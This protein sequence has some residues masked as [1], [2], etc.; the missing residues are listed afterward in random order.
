MKDM[1][2]PNRLSV[3]RIL[4]IPVMTALLYPRTA[5]CGAAALAVFCIAAATDW[6]DGRI[7]R[8]NGQVTVFGKF[9]DPVADKLLVLSAFVMLVYGGLMP[10]WATVLVLARELCV[11][12]L[13]MVASGQ[14]RVIAAGRLGKWKTAV[15]DV[16]I[17]WLM[18][19][20]VPVKDH[21]L[22]IVL[23]AAAVLLT[24]WSGA[25]YFIRNR[26]A[27]KEREEV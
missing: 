21:W 10:A 15:Q 12:G 13:R 26:D 3:L 4:L 7:A 27:L 20:R 9:I 18:A 17:I 24:V 8:R 19:S 6:L 5:A 23:C 22:G 25:E 11:D 14:G 16:L 2:L 1:N